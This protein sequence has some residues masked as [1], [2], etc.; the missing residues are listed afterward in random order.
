MLK[1]S[2]STLLFSLTRIFWIMCPFWESVGN[3][4]IVL[5][6]LYL[7]W[8]FPFPFFPFFKTFRSICLLL[9]DILGSILRHHPFINFW[10]KS[11]HTNDL[12]NKAI[13]KKDIFMDCSLF[14]PFGKISY[15]SLHGV[16]RDPIFSTFAANWVNMFVKLGQW[17]NVCAWKRLYLFVRFLSPVSF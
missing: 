7:L 12:F 2:V 9:I 3:M 13:W 4:Q 6:L 8:Y 14:L 17:A 5:W 11:V 16:F 15:T 1:R 10:A